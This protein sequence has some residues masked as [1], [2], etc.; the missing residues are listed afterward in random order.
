MDTLAC[1]ERSELRDRETIQGQSFNLVKTTY[2]FKK[3]KKR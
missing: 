3:K 1:P 2:I